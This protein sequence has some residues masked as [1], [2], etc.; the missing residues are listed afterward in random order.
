MLLTVIPKL[1]TSFARDLAKPVTAARRLFE[2]IRFSTGCFAAIDVMF[3]I[4]PQPRSFIPGKQ[5]RDISTTFMRTPAAAWSHC[6]RDSSSNVPEGGPPEFVIRMSICP[7][8]SIPC[9]KTRTMSSGTV[10]SAGIPMTSTPLRSRMDRHAPERASSPRAHKISDVPSDASSSATASPSPWLE[11]ATSAVFPAKPRSIEL[12][13][14]QIIVRLIQ[15]VLS[16]RAE[17][18]HVQGIFQ[19]FRLVKHIRR[20]HKHLAGPNGNFLGTVFADPEMQG[21]LQ[22][23]GELLIVMRVLGHDTTLFQINV[24]QH[25]SV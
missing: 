20:D 13:L 24:R 11:A 8:R 4:R 21:S 22:H 14:S 6:S 25:H 9:S 7:N 1:A 23:I 12:F 5:S 18:V 17:Y 19:S 3:R 16:R 2:S 10:M 15:P